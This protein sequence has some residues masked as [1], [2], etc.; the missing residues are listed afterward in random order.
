[1]INY[2]QKEHNIKRIALRGF[3]GL[4]IILALCM[5]LSGTIKTLATAKVKLTMP[6]SDY[7]TDSIQ[8]TGYLYFSD[9]DDIFSNAVP[10][11]T[12]LTIRKVYVTPG[13]RIN[14]GD[15]L[16]EADVTNFDAVL[17]ELNENYTAIA[18]EL[19]QLQL[20][21]TYLHM[22]SSDEAWVNAYDAYLLTQQEL[23]NAQIALSA[24]ATHLGIT[25]IDGKLP[26]DIIDDTLL[27]K[28]ALVEDLLAQVDE[29]RSA[30]ENANLR[31]IQPAVKA[32]IMQERRL[33]NNLVSLQEQM[34]ELY[35]LSTMAQAVT[36]P[37]DGFILTVNINEGDQFDGT[38]PAIVMSGESAEC[39]LQADIS[40]TSRTITEG[41]P[42]VISGS[43]GYKV[44]STVSRNSFDAAGNPAIQ[45]T[46][47]S[48]AISTLGG[49]S[50][51]LK[52][53]VSMSVEYV[54]DKVS[55]LIPAAAVRGITGNNF[56]YVVEETENLLGQ[57]VL[58]L[59]KQ[60][61]TI[62][63][64][65]GDMVAVAEEIT[66]MQIAYMEDR[67]VSEGSEVISYDD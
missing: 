65:A 54:S 64:E 30:L 62:A 28:Q 36:A 6:T 35:L 1:M 37:H 4:L 45:V 58:T 14:A 22:S 24:N 47:P 23:L 52:K 67:S 9:T 60:P 7:L 29:K 27:E 61:I 63:D 21:N 66:N 18:E 20:D 39:Y 48:S 5:F 3:V 8:T 10:E 26:D 32:F 19:T 56:I 59:A 44:E 51:L 31:G 40:G 50:G 33:Q 41:T 42:V 25:L 55:T 17:E 49:A 38:L 57:S 43:I 11:N 15:V 34:T 13:R 16:F 53:G 12:S 2:T 46:I